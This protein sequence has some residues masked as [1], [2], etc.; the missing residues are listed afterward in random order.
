MCGRYSLSVPTEVLARIFRLASVPALTPRYNISPSQDAP[1]IRSDSGGGRRL[2]S[3][4]WG[5]IPTW[6]DDQTIGNRLIMARAESVPTKP[7]FRT[8]FRHRRCLIPADGF[9]EWLKSEGRKQPYLIRMHE[10]RPFAIAGLWEAWRDQGGKKIE[11]FT[12]LT[13]TANEVAGQVHNRMPVIIGPENYDTWLDPKQ[14]DDEKLRSLLAPFAADQME[15]FPV[16]SRVNSPKND[17]AE[18][19]KP[20][21]PKPVAKSRDSEGDLL[22]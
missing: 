17:D 11:S 15:A 19:I 21:R 13:T 12:V 20:V 3:L 7:A 2:D 8:A 14:E 4:R 5:L 16:S 18:C 22:F 9:Y 10:G 6:A 1:V